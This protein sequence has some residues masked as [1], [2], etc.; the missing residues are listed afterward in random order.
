MHTNGG[1]FPYGIV[2]NCWS[3]N[4]VSYQPQHYCWEMNLPLTKLY[5]LNELSSYSHLIVGIYLSKS[6]S[7]ILFHVIRLI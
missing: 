6:I 1:K 7:I 3:L 5:E 4:S 2:D